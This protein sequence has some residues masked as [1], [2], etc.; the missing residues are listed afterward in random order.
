MPSEFNQ[1]SLPS[2]GIKLQTIAVGGVGIHS[3]NLVHRRVLEYFDVSLSSGEEEQVTLGVP[4]YLV[5]LHSELCL[6]CDLKCPCVDNADYVFLK[7]GRRFFLV[8]KK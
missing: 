4:A 1:V 6:L 5:H 2:P 8:R 3:M 7:V